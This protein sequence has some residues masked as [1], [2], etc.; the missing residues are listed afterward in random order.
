MH[1]F[2]HL[3]LIE[4]FLPGLPVSIL[5]PLTCAILQC[6]VLSIPLLAVRCLYLTLGAAGS[7]GTLRRLLWRPADSDYLETLADRHTGIVH[8]LCV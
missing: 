6:I 5:G 8:D 4:P 7:L 3:V 2:S 1:I